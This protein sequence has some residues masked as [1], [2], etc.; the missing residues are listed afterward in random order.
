MSD[1]K[2]KL[3]GHVIAT[4]KMP[5]FDTDW[6]NKEKVAEDYFEYAEPSIGSNGQLA[7]VRRTCILLDQ[8]YEELK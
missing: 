3:I 8:R 2:R 5:I 1:P 4:I 6:V 7:T